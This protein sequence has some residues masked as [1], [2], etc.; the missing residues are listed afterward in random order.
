[1]E[2]TAQQRNDIE[3]LAAINYGADQIAMYLDVDPKEF[4]RAFTI[5]ASDPLY[6]P[7]NARYH[8]DRG[9]LITQAEIDKA[10]LKRAKDGNLTSIQQWKKDA[11]GR[12]LENLKHQVFYDE[13]RKEYEQ[14]QGLIER[15]EIK[16]LPER[17]VLYYE[18]IDFIRSLYNKYES[19]SF[20]INAVVVQW[21]KLSKLLAMQ[22]YH[23]SLNFFNLD[24]PV[25]V[26]AWANIYADRLDN[27]ARLCFEMNDFETAR[28]L[29]MNAAEL[30]GV[31][32]E[33]P[34]QIPDELLDRRP[35]FYTIR[36]KDIGVPEIN[37][38]DLAAFIDGLDITEKQR[39][40][41]RREAMIEDV[42]FELADHVEEKN[43]HPGG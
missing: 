15:G 26:R 17:V 10:N 8:Y 9:K 32:K 16:D 31:G 19:K 40:K 23:E 27:M 37:R 12:K 25:K 11:A 4:R 18:Q 6:G 24:N 22:L 13:E 43:N 34:D 3:Q 7:G 35:V 20:I 38:N 1:M 2:L 41:A 39:L 30:R 5:S 29:T 28:R 42:P 33:I 14:L 36:L 21:P